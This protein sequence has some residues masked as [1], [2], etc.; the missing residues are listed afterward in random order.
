MA[1]LRVAVLV[2]GTGSLLQAIL[3]GQDSSYEV[4]VVA[5]DRAGVLALDR[6]E[7]AGIESVVVEF[8]KGE[9][10]EVA[11]EKMAR[12]LRAYDVGLAVN[13]GFMKILTANYFDILGVPAMNSHPALLPAFPGAHGVR[14]AL[15]AGVTVTGTTIH[16]ATPDVDAGPI[17]FQEAVEVLP[18]DTEETLHARIK[19]VEQR[20]YPEAIRLFAEGRLKIEGSRVHILPAPG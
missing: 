9:P 20:L 2:S 8:P 10:R 14:D 13:A 17:I 11:S 12:A 19:E 18:E 1:K 6:C 7:A 5:S 3:D 4:V 15:A 16:F